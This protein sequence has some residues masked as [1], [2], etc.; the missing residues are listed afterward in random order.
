MDQVIDWETNTYAGLE[1]LDEEG[2]D[3]VSQLGTLEVETDEPE[4]TSGMM[5]DLGELELATQPPRL[6]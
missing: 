5:A 2:H 3:R 1:H 6:A 4:M